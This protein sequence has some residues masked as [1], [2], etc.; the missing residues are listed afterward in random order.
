MN[1]PHRRG[2]IVYLE[3]QIVCMPHRRNWVHPPPPQASVSPPLD[4]K[5]GEGMRGPRLDRKPGTLSVY[6]V[7]LA[8]QPHGWNSKV[9][10]KPPTPGQVI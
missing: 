8:N 9:I 1:Q 3:Y 10:Y 6:S 7:A 2:I 4:P 5:G